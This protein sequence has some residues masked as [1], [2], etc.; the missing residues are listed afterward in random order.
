MLRPAKG[1]TLD[2]KRHIFNRDSPDDSKLTQI[3]AL[4]RTQQ[5]YDIKA[6]VE[7]EPNNIQFRFAVGCHESRY[8]GTDTYLIGARAAQLS[9]SSIF[10]FYKGFH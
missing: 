1:Q 8:D 7:I 10:F 4:F 6:A 9:A 2:L 3:L 5:N